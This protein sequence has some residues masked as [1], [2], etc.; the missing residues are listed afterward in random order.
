MKNLIRF[1][2]ALVAAH[3]VAPLWATDPPPG[4]AY[5][6]GFERNTDG[7]FDRTNGGFGTITRRPSGYSDGI[8]GYANGINSATGNWHARL[9]GNDNPCDRTQFGTPCYGPF[10]RWGG[11]S[12]TFPEGGYS[13]QV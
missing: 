11:Y 10:T 13:T 8:G 9:T 6:N 5:F 7:W 3:M 2:M 1:A 12:S 4:A